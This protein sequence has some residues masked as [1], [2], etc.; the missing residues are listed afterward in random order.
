[1]SASPAAKAPRPVLPAPF[2]SYLLARLAEL[3]ARAD[4][5]ARQAEAK[6]DLKT[7]L[8]ATRLSVSIL[9]H[10]ARLASKCPEAAQNWQ[11]PVLSS[12]AA[13]ASRPEAQAVQ[14]GY[15]I[16]LVKPVNADWHR[17]K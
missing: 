15:S 5:L 16:P 1:M 14:T 12:P 8:T 2:G 10:M 9:A 3:D 11:P 4:V 17:Q 6:G 13:P 7:A